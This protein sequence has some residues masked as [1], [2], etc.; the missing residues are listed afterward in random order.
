MTLIRVAVGVDHR[1]LD[2]VGEVN[3]VGP[4]LA[5][6]V[7][8]VDPL[9]GW[10]I[11]NARRVPKAIPCLRTLLAFFAGSQ[12]NRIPNL[13]EMYLRMSRCKVLA[14]GLS[15]AQGSSFD[16]MMVPEAANVPP[17]PWQTEIRAPGIWAGAVPPTWRTL[18]YSGTC[19][20]AGMDLAGS[21]RR[22]PA[23]H[24][25]DARGGV[26]PAMKVPASPRG[27]K[28]RSSRP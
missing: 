6:L 4:H 20:H 7:T 17:T 10:S 9:H 28:P 19:R 24:P 15:R 12:V 21:R 11:E 27:T 14:S 3:C 23:G 22:G 25:G 8:I 1:N 5:V 13:Y 16:M 2:A 26:M 18:Y